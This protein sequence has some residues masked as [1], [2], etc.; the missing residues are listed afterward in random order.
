VEYVYSEKE[1]NE[2]Q[3]RLG[4]NAIVQRF[5]GLGEMN[6]SQLWE[7][8]MNPE[9]RK[10]LQVGIE[11]AAYA[12]RLLSILMGEKVEPRRRFIEE[13]AK[14]VENIDA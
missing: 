9:T 1:V 7:T 10:F 6:P 11:D 5:K 14:T 4:A 3:Q 12:E 13:N 2:V 8:T